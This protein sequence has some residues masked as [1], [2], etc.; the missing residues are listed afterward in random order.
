M[1]LPL[2]VALGFF[3]GKQ[4]D[5]MSQKIL[6][7]EENLD[8]GAASCLSRLVEQ[9]MEILLGLLSDMDDTKSWLLQGGNGTPVGFQREN[10]A[11]AWF[12]RVLVLL[13]VICVNSTNATMYCD[14]LSR[15]RQMIHRYHILTGLYDRLRA[16]FERAF[17]SKDP[18][19]LRALLARVLSCFGDSLIRTSRCRKECCADLNRMQTLVLRR[20]QDWSQ[21]LASL[22]GE[23]GVQEASGRGCCIHP[24]L[25]TDHWKADRVQ[26]TGKETVFSVFLFLEMSHTFS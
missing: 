8:E 4:Q 6:D 20:N 22:S 9:I 11:R 13:L 21:M 2:T 16:E 19:H 25:R 5:W 10:D 1:Y 14:V 24:C 12:R 15:L 23:V 17:H 18:V 7:S 3:C 26:S